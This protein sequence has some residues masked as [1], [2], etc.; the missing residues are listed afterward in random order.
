MVRVALWVSAE[1]SVLAV[2]LESVAP[3]VLVVPQV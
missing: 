2:R 3:Q 1:P